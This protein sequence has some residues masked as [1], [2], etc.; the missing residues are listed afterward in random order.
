[1]GVISRIPLGTNFLFFFRPP[2]PYPPLVNSDDYV[3]GPGGRARVESIFFRKG[4]IFIFGVY[5][6]LF[7]FGGGIF[8]VF[9]FMENR[10]SSRK[11]ITTEKQKNGSSPAALFQNVP[12]AVSDPSRPN[13]KFEKQIQI[14][15]KENS[16]RRDRFLKHA[17]LESELVQSFGFSNTFYLL[18]CT[19]YLIKDEGSR[20]KNH[21]SRIKDQGSRIQDQGPRIK[22]QGSWILF[23][24]E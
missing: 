4:F 6:F 16:I 12:S 18:P 17:A 20:I 11:H 23:W 22:N 21:A 15:Q 9:F 19:F 8:L 7:I 13:Q 24:H 1:M 14:T 3:G 2:P 10:E 5:R